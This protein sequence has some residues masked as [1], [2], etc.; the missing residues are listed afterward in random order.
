[1]TD[2]IKNLQL[3]LAAACELIV[4]LGEASEQF[5][6]ALDF[7]AQSTEWLL[8][9]AQ[10]FI[11]CRKALDAFEKAKANAPTAAEVDQA[12]DTPKLPATTV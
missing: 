9:N 10:S 5:A 6:E 4:A 11:R 2:E 1:M 8:K 12:G 3:Q 7:K